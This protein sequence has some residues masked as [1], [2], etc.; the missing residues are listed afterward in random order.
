[1]LIIFINLCSVPP[2]IAIRGNNTPVV[3]NE[4]GGSFELCV[5]KRSGSISATGLTV[6]LRFIDIGPLPIAGV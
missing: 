4:T 5:V 1:M 2:A 3:L 6:E